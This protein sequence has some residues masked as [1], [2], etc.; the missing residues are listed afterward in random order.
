MQ[1]FA[2]LNAVMIP[3]AMITA[4]SLLLLGIYD[5]Y[6]KIV[7]SLRSLSS[8]RRGLVRVLNE[9]TSPEDHSRRQQIDEE[10]LLLRRRL[11]YALRQMQTIVAA[12]TLFLIASLLIAIEVAMHIRV[13]I[14]VAC[15][16]CLGI[17]GLIIAM[18]QALLEARMIWRVVDAEV[19]EAPAAFGAHPSHSA[20]HP[21]SA[22]KPSH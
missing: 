4:C 19:P 8:E 6:S 17:A 11:G 14:A 7:A 5:K 16:V 9:R 20:N 10:C 15:L 1:T 12:T 18:A 13:D 22:L 2:V 3:A 21:S